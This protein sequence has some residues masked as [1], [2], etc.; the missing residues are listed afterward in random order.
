MRIGLLGGTFNP[1]HIG[2]V[3]CAQ[4]ARLQLDLDVVNLVPVCVP[5][6]REL[7]DDPGC[8]VRLE[9]CRAA[10]TGHEGLDVLDDEI[11]RG[12]ASYTIDTLEALS[13]SHPTDEL[14][15]VI[16]ADQA[17]AFGNWHDPQRIGGLARIAVAARADADRK[18]ALAE[19]ERAAGVEP[20]LVNMPRI[21]ISSSLIRDRI[22]DGVASD[23]LLPEAV[24]REIRER[25]LYE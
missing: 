3:I 23:H 7:D 2:H 17:L 24:V 19:V 21:D 5:P 20:V 25:G 9:L 8:A 1:P 10:I 22:A 15:L 13:K 12:G 4:E 16:G 6:H 14:T 11:E 18:A